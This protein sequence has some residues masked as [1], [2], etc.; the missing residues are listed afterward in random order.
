MVKLINS[1][2]KTVMW[3]HES[4]LKEYL[5]MGHKLAPLPDAPKKK[6]PTKKTKAKQGE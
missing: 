3:V 2:T 6:A 4:R 1:D 5:A